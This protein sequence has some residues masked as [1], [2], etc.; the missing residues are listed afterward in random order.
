M[1]SLQVG[2]FAGRV[3]LPARLFLAGNSMWR[4]RP[5]KSACAEAAA[6]A[7]VLPACRGAAQPSWLL[8]RTDASG[9]A[10]SRCWKW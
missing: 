3:A 10:A 1:N 8:I 9:L 4:C 5:G 2:L 6:A 7:P